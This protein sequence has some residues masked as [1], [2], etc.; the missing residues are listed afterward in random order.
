MGEGYFEG[1]TVELSNSQKKHLEMFLR[2]LVGEWELSVK[3]ITCKGSDKNPNVVRREADGNAKITESNLGPL[4]IELNKYY[5]A[6][7]V[8]QNELILLLNLEAISRFEISDTKLSVSEWLWRY[9]PD[10]RLLETI[11]TIEKSNKGVSIELFYFE[12]GYYI[13]SQLISLKSH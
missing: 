1:K 4:R 3:E 2:D 10:R 12:Q 6:D 13:S 9:T 8:S 11:Y 7:R 5:R